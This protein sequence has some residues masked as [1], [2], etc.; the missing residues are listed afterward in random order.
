MDRANFAGIL[1]IAIPA[2]EASSYDKNS[3]STHSISPLVSPALP[4]DQ[5]L[6]PLLVDVLFFLL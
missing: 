5:L 1:P 6:P 2:I 3:A 4:L